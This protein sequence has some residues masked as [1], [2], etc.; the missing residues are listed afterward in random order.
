MKLKTYQQKTLDVLRRFFELCR[1]MG[2]KAAFEEMTTN[3]N[4]LQERLANIKNKY[5][6]WDGI[7]NTPRVCIKIPTG[8]GK[9]LLAAHSIKIA[10]Q[11]WCEKDNGIVLWFVPSET[12]RKQ[13]VEAL[14]E[15]RHPYR[16]ALD[17]Q[18]KG[19]VKIFDLDE[20]FNIRPSDVE[21]NTCIIVGTIQSF[22]KEDTSKYNVYK[23]NENL[24]EHFSRMNKAK[25]A[26][27]EKTDDGK[28]AKY[29]FANLLFYYRP[30]MIVDEAHKVVTDLSKETQG[31]INPAAIIEWTA[32]PKSD[33]NTLFA[34]RAMEL[35]EEEMIKLPIALVEHNGWE[36]AVIDAIAR[37]AMLEKEAEKEKEK[38]RPILLFQAQSKNLP[39]NVEFLKNY[40]VDTANLPEEEIKIATGDQKEL[41]NINLFDENQQTRFIITVEALK[42]G[43]DCSFAYVLC[44][45]ANV[46]SDTSIAQLLGRVMRMPYAKTRKSAALNKAY[47]FVVS[48]SFSEAAAALTEKLKEKGFDE[49]EAK[50]FVQQEFPI[51]D[52][53]PF[54]QVKLSGKIDKKDLPSNIEIDKDNTLFFKPETTD[55]DI[56]K[57]CEKVDKQQAQAIG[58]KFSIFKKINAE[59]TPASKG[60]PFKVPRLRFEAQ[61]EML[62]AD[63]ETIFE[64]FDWDLHEYDTC[65][66]TE[67]EFDIKEAPGKGFFIDIDGNSLKYSEAGKEQLLPFMEDIDVWTNANLIRWLDIHIK[68]DDIPRTSMLFWLEKIITHLTK[69]R[70]IS[71]T[72]LMV[73]KFALL[74]RLHAKITV[75]RNKAKEK[76]YELFSE[77]G[78]KEFSFD[79]TVSFSAGMYDGVP[80]YQGGYAF[81]KHYFGNKKVPAFDGKIDGEEFKCAQAID[82]SDSVRYWLRNVERHSV[83]FRLPL[84]NGNFYPDFIA[85]LN[86]DRIL[87]VEYKG[88]HLLESPDTKKKAFIGEIWEKESKGKGLFLMATKDAEGKDVARQIKEKI[89]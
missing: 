73:A 64:C 13:T 16:V 43:W 39:Q 50:S 54:N 75:A 23:D 10:L 15:N 24:E 68:Q 83:S 37:R 42:E 78:R 51:I 20:K 22:V 44:S 69:S 84:H 38:I 57:I 25:M 70:N 14:K 52:S 19:K 55:D 29:S 33:N 2:H 77:K 31:R 76:S 53:L 66:L 72:K 6:V 40:L 28:R 4:D 59:Q 56:K 9:T 48:P 81:K 46:K 32:T 87:I 71:I 62:F 49:Q 30:I 47:A 35:K 80:L 17:D 7:P 74:N 61:G 21:G 41:D 88:K 5:I 89:K 45:L 1:I 27:M 60:E 86:D 65:K 36:N 63:S 11:L 34:V 85:I 58:Q 12:I 79:Y 8:G 67:S 82:T 26:D 18:F 3:D